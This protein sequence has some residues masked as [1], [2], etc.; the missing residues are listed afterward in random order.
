MRF[1]RAAS[2]WSTLARVKRGGL[3][4]ETV[5]PAGV[6]IHWPALCADPFWRAGWT[7]PC[8]CRK[9]RACSASRR[10][11]FSASA[12]SQADQVS[13]PFVSLRKLRA[14]SAGRGGG[15]GGSPWGGHV[16]SVRTKRV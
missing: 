14:A 8:A 2:A 10:L 12:R 7:Y 9:A 6:V 3:A 11:I 5:S 4:P 16:T 15:G 1:L 13:V